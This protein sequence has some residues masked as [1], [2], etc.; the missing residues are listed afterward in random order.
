MD[1]LMR[2]SAVAGSF[3]ATDSGRLQAVNDVH[4][5]LNRTLV[6]RVIQ[7]SSLPEIQS[8]IHS[9]RTTGQ[10]LSIAGSRH[11]MGTQQFA[12]GSLLL[13]T[14]SL[15]QVLHFDAVNG[16]I[17]VES[18]M[19][20]P[21]LIAYL[22]SAQV[23][24]DRPWAIRQKQ[25]GADLLTIGGAVSA[26]IHGRGL[27]MKPFIADIEALK[28]VD[29]SGTVRRCDRNENKDLFHLIIGG[30][31]LFGFIYSV[32]LRLAP[33]QMLRRVVRLLD[34]EDLIPHLNDRIDAGFLYGDF[35]FAIDDQSE[36]FLRRGVCSCY[37][38]VRDQ[39]AYLPPSRKLRTSD[40]ERLLYLAHVN[41]SRAF[42][43]YASYYLSTSGQ[44]YWSDTHQLTEYV[45][46]YHTR[47]DQRIGC[48]SKASEMITE[49]YVPRESLADFMAAARQELRRH[50]AKVIYG[51]IR[52]IEQDDESFLAWARDSYACIIFNLHVE[53][54]P[55]D[56][57]RNAGIFQQLI[58]LARE[59][60]GSYYLTYHR[61]AT[62][63]QI[64]DC[65]PRFADFL[66]LKRQYDPGEVFQSD[67]Y[68]HHRQM[69]AS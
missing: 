56:I 39:T 12:S 61:Y 46:D 66:R 10:E 32:T 15:N 36:D 17:E 44:L 50:Q 52:L 18:G 26:N 51:T 5:Q 37:E 67:W 57:A 58:N 48:N 13:D 29:S 22:W 63:E 21:E 9:A 28:V 24:S 40:W 69:F 42:A 7:V 68:R 20:W 64:E 35:Q 38:P 45:E 4:S 16:L 59:R 23:G 14:R 54:T 19:P 47:L 25:T 60:S 55:Q 6:G 34:V 2:S 11:A 49:L 65:H 30:Y 62:R 53:H 43:E 3:P 1:T 8:A 27:R 41:P 33:R 31:G